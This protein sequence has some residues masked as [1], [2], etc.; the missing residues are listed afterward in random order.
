MG[1]DSTPIQLNGVDYGWP[2]RPVVVVCIDGGDPEYLL[3]GLEKG[4]LP[5]VQRLM[6]AGFSTTARGTMPSFTCPNNMSLATGAPPSMHGVSGNFHLDRATGEAV[7]MTGPE[8]LRTRSVLAEFARH[9]AGVVCITAK[10]KLRAQLGKE[11]PIESGKVINFSAQCADQCSA[12]V[13]GIED[14]LKLMDR[15]LPDM[16]SADLSLFVLDAGIR[17]LRTVHPQLSYLS[18]TDFIQHAYPPGHPLADRFYADLDDRVG[19]L[20]ETGAVVA[21]TAD[22]GMTDMSHEDGTP[23]VIWL[24]EELD[25]V[26][27]P[28]STTVICPITDAFVGHHGA[29]GGFVARLLSWRSGP[30]SMIDLLTHL[31]GVAKVWSRASVLRELDLPFDVEADYAVM[32]EEGMALGVRPEAHDI[33]ALRGQRLRSHGSIWE[34]DVPFMISEPLRPD[35][36]ERSAQH[37]VQSYQIFD[38]AIN[39]TMA[40]GRPAADEG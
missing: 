8:M 38:Y 39:G 32:G 9:G 40:I 37:T 22:H 7:P 10:D 12:A 20:L 14:V 11:M 26:F 34:A 36:A 19:Q 5:N 33:S 30:G 23:R 2:E 27:G 25:R 28:G 24:Q 31:K 18:L 15:P 35:Y 6:A 16:Y 17:L 3:S 1:D 29:L 13:N 4:I 21:L